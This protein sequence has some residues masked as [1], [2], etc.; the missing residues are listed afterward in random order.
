MEKCLGEVEIVK[1]GYYVLPVNKKMKIEIVGGGGGGAGALVGGYGSY[2]NFGYASA[3]GG[4]G[5]S[6]ER[7]FI[8]IG[9]QSRKVKIYVTISDIAMGGKGGVLGYAQS[10]LDGGDTSIYICGKMYIAKGGKGGLLAPN[11]TIG[12][13]GGSGLY[14]GG[15]GSGYASG[16]SGGIVGGNA[17]NPFS[18]DNLSLYGGDG[19]NN[20]ASGGKGSTHLFNNFDYVIG[21]GGGGGGNGGGV[22]GYCGSE[23]NKWNTV[24]I[25]RRRRRRWI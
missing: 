20:S 9:R 19:A 2:L 12:G 6:G 5:G 18:S 10:G 24:W 8:K 11:P 17:G 14:G 4:G 15:G 1:S 13:E 21:G 25:R 16:G 23:A 7:R 3:G 22:G